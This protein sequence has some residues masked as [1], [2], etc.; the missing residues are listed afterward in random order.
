[1]Q[2]LNIKSKKF[3]RQKIFKIAKILSLHVILDDTPTFCSE[4]LDVIL[5]ESFIDFFSV[6]KILVK[7]NFK[8][9]IQ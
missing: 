7:L 1:M 4:L 8:I 9:L 5:N 3:C 6:K 2:N